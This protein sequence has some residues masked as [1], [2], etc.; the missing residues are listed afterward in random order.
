MA[1]STTSH[2]PLYLIS[3]EFPPHT[4]KFA[5]TSTTELLTNLAFQSQEKTN[6]G[7][8]TGHCYHS[9]VRRDGGAGRRGGVRA[10]RDTPLAALYACDVSKP[11]TF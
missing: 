10:P 4:P 6:T 9:R 2:P 11:Y 1:S 3:F 8:N 5:E 7:I